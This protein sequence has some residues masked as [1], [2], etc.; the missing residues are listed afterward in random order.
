[1]LKVILWQENQS[2]YVRICQP[3]YLFVIKFKKKNTYSH[4]MYRCKTERSTIHEKIAK[5]NICTHTGNIIQKTG[6]QQC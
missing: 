3:T 5:K 6:N 4:H 1:M 2:T